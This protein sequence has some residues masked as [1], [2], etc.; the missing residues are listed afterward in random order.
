VLGAFIFMGGM[1]EVTSDRTMTREFNDRE[2]PEMALY[3]EGRGR[4]PP[5]VQIYAIDG[6]FFFGAA[7][8]FK[9]TLGQ[10][11]GKP[12][13]LVLLMRNVPAIDST[14]LVALRD[15]IRR[16][17]QGGTRVIL[18]GVHAQP[19]AAISRSPLLTELGEENLVGGIDEALALAAVGP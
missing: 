2:G 19:M 12:Q 8:K 9:E 3:A 1:W 4:I 10:V 13:V 6:P 14:G 18:A 16:F 15:V 7:E 17:R 5:G 11:A